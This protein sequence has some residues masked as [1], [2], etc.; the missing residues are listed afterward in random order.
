ME[1]YVFEDMLV[2]YRDTDGM[3]LPVA[4][5]REKAI[6]LYIEKMEL[7]PNDIWHA[8]RIEELENS[9]WY[10]LPVGRPGLLLAELMSLACRIRPMG[11]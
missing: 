10:T 1:Y 7:N 9:R 6:E 2:K 5:S 8:D 4:E 3:C 11:T